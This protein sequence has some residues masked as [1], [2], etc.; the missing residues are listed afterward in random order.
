MYSGS[1]TPQKPTFLG[2]GAHKAGT[3][4]LYSQLISHPEVYMPPKK[5]I[6]FFDRS[7]RYPSPN[8]LSEPSPWIRPFKLEPQDLKSTAVD[9]AR[10]AKCLLTG[11]LEKAQWYRKWLFGY[12]NERWYASLFESHKNY[13]A[14]GEISPAY[15]ILE[16]QDIAK[17]KAL[18]PDM[19]LILMLRDPI[20]RVW[21]NMRYGAGKGRLEVDLDS[22]DDII[23]TLKQPKVALRGDY[24]RTLNLYLEHFD[25]S[26]LLVCFYEA[27]RRDPAGLM[28]AIATFLGISPFAKANINAKKRV[29]ASKPRSMP[30]P[31][32]D[33]L[34]ETYGFQ[35]ERLA[36]ALGS[37][38]NTWEGADG[39]AGDRLLSPVGG[40]GSSWNNGSNTG[41]GSRLPMAP[42]LHPLSFIR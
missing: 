15:S 26:Q 7:W 18:N 24:E 29:N 33:Y 38:A 17:I 9:A 35:A 20:D 25:A 13:R 3:S 12:Y 23:S 27:I 42:A 8:I 28:L 2:I 37:Y 14:Y 10:M 21:S 41:S 30:E 36:K 4:W 22:P 16:T 39:A 31:V 11:D 5:E 34:L 32:K 19:K 1:Q 6:H 40:S